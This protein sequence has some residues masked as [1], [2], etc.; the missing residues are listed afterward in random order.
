MGPFIC[1]GT[2]FLVK[3]HIGTLQ[4]NEGEPLGGKELGSTSA[5]SFFLDRRTWKSA[6]LV[7]ITSISH[8]SFVYHFA[9][10]S[11]DQPLGLPVGQHVFVRLWKK[12]TGEMVQQAYMPIS[13]Q[14]EHG[15]IDLLIK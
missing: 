15:S 2:H 7:K 1:F 5:Y 13:R 9:L 14:E 8:D 11:P 12:T 3:F 6:K 4:A 10:H